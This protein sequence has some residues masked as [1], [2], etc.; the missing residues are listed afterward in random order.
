VRD[1][2][3]RRAASNDQ[4]GTALLL[5]PLTPHHLESLTFPALMMTLMKKLLVMALVADAYHGCVHDQLTQTTVSHEVHYAV[6]P[7]HETAAHWR[8]EST[9]AAAEVYAASEFLRVRQAWACSNRLSDFSRAATHAHTAAVQ[10][11]GRFG[12]GTSEDTALHLKDSSFWPNSSP[13]P[14]PETL[15][16]R[17]N[18]IPT[19]PTRC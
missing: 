10:P 12:F 16:R 19:V 7:F 8:T 1:A 18:D 14:P 6:H 3:A 15:T 11:R 9:G 4:P 2:V 13:A 17:I 5:A